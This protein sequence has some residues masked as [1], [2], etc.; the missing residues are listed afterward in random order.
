MSSE[1]IVLVKRPY[2]TVDPVK[3]N[4]KTSADFDGT[5]T[6]TRNRDSIDFSLTAGGSI[7]KFDG[8]DNKFEGAKLSG[9][10]DLFAV[11]KKPSAAMNDVELTLTLS[12]GSKKNGP[13]AKIQLTA[14]ELTLDI[15]EPR[16][17]DT[18]EPL[19]LPTATTAP[20]AG[21]TP[22]DKYYL[23]RP[24]PE[25]VKPKVDERAT[26][27]VRQVK[28]AAFKGNLE[29]TADNAQIQLYTSEKSSDTQT[30]IALPLTLSP[31]KI[32]PA[33]FKLFVEGATVSSKPRETG[34][35]IGIKGV[36]GEGDHVR[37]TVCHT[38]IVSNRKPADLKIV[39]TVP[40]KP[41]R[42]TKSAYFVAPIIVGLKYDVQMRPHV[43]LATP[44]AYQWKTASDKIKLKDDTREV[45]GCH[46][47]K[48]SGALNDV[49]LDLFLTTN[50]GKLKKRHRLTVVHVEMSPIT[51][52]D[53]LVHTDPINK[54][55]NPSGCVILSGGDAGDKTK[56]PTYKITKIS[57]NLAWTD[58]DPRIAWRIQGGDSKGDEK[59]DGKAEFRNDDKAKYGKKIQ[60]YGTAGG[61]VLIEPYSGGY[62]YGMFRAHVAAIRQVKYRINRLFTTA[63]AA[64]PA[65]PALPEQLAQPAFPG[66]GAVPAQPAV[67]HLPA[68]DARPAQAA[69]A[70]YAPTATPAEAQLHMKIVNI[71]LRQ[72]GIEMIPDNSGEVASANRPASAALPAVVAQPALTAQPATPALAGPPPRPA[73]PAVLA[74][75]AVPNLPALA[76][77]PATTANNKV[78]KAALDGFVEKVTL[79]APGIFDVEVNNDRL[80]FRPRGPQEVDTI[81]INARNEVI[82]FA[83]IHSQKSADALATA[84]LCPWNHAPLARANPP[85]QP[86]TKASYTIKDKSSPSTSLIPKTG[87][88][89][90]V[91]VD[92]VKMVVLSADMAWEGGS[93]ATRKEELLWG[94]IVPTRTIDTSVMGLAADKRYLAYGNTLA[95]ELGHIFGLGHRGGGGVPD[96]LMIPPAENLMHPSNPP[97]QAE[98]LD[99]IQVK[100]IRFSEALFRNP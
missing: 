41:E 26:L 11:A 53:S 23:G 30:P 63:Q 97:P 89:D 85:R 99:L 32:V 84:L 36:K 92:E 47:E 17:N 25:Q 14:V 76:A 72:A 3:V 93:P 33:G 40:E 98:N 6:V 79:A 35:K 66:H 54:I 39:A 91:P 65:V 78:G 50:L 29:L 15:C 13:P 74:R 95:H 9:G 73:Q 38:E 4:L 49:L 96:G 88:P 16:V 94:V 18:T 77:R 71:Y 70:A 61:D 100:A 86:Y 69:R 81:K 87:I 46:G 57:P 21:A 68:V 58:D 12:G 83:Y 80:V 22:T 60:V 10:V 43:A 20:A 7:L 55:E 28:P 31:S 67:P 2:T 44:S 27:I 59:Y 8:K 82:T 5:G 45:V 62:G 52:G 48:L 90:D 1:Y 34:L 75:P 42:K 19:P 37:L 56:V 24:L 64:H 51:T